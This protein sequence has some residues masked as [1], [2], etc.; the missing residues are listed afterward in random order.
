MKMK[1]QN[2][3]ENHK[4]NQKRMK[5]MKSL[6]SA[7]VALAILFTGC[8]SP[9]TEP[10]AVQE[11]LGSISG[12]VSAPGISQLSG[13]LVV[14]EREVAGLS[15]KVIGTMEA[16]GLHAQTVLEDLTGNQAAYSEYQSAKEPTSR[17]GGQTLFTAVSKEDGS[18]AITGLPDG[19][20][21]VSFQKDHTQGFSQQGVM[22]ANSRGVVLDVELTAT[23]SIS[24]NIALDR[25]GDSIFGTF[26]CVAGTSYVAA[27]DVNGDFVISDVP[28][29]TYD[30]VVYHAG[31]EPQT[32]AGLTVTATAD[33][34]LASTVTLAYEGHPP[35][36]QSVIADP[37]VIG[38]GG[39]VNLEVLASDEDGDTLTYSWDAPVGTL[40]S[41]DQAVTDFI[42]PNEQGTIQVDVTVSDGSYNAQG[43]VVVM[44][45]NEPVVNV[46]G[47]NVLPA[48]VSVDK[49]ATTALSAVVLP[50]SATLKAVT[51]SSS[52]EAIATVNSA[53]VVTGVE[54]GVV[55]ITATTQDGGFE[56]S[57]VVTVAVPV[58]GVSV[59]GAPSQM[60]IGQQL[61]FATEITPANADNQEII[62]STS[63]DSIATVD[64]VSGLVT[65]VALGNVTI[66]AT[67]VDGGYTDSF[68]AEIILGP[69]VTFDFSTHTNLIQEDWRIDGI[70]F[71]LR[72]ASDVALSEHHLIYAGIDRSYS[73][74]VNDLGDFSVDVVLSAG[75][76]N[77]YRTTESFSVGSISEVVTIEIDA[78][79]TFLKGEMFARSYMVRKD[80]TVWAWGDN[81]NRNLGLDVVD[82]WVHPMQRFAAEEWLKITGQIVL[83]RD[84][85]LWAFGR[86]EEELGLG[87]EV[88]NFQ[89]PMQ[90]G[91]DTDWSDIYIT[92][93]NSFL[94]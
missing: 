8:Q 85:T 15:A 29:G 88:S 7:L 78:H 37:F 17:S 35:V 83:K 64:G 80:G 30:L 91:T 49:G 40:V 2:G 14:A 16:S 19:F 24:G 63:D 55:S 48:T 31:Y 62:W 27:V 54:K 92:Y 1:K 59:V 86:G 25:A 94:P 73:L 20:Y 39:S 75:E 72:D 79:D 33:T 46:S 66:T 70:T 57:A 18:Y 84:G 32:I 4:N 93:S 34:P 51:W 90:I 52:D 50:A 13:T 41:F 58:T 9:V 76:V 10:A 5:T 74:Y 45:S 47:V 26:V 12:L 69:L 28:V 61:S 67:T 53:G 36:I 71:V 3:T 38:P 60:F 23:G 11:S 56:S 22:V 65:A 81:L 42:V 87:R 6:M 89:T 68:T 44:V 21:T 82:R 43:K 77:V